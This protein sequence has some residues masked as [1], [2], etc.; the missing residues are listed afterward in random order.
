LRTQW[1]PWAASALIAAVTVWFVLP[2]N[3]LQ[4]QSPLEDPSSAPGRGDTL[5][6]V[7]DHVLYSTDLALVRASGSAAETWADDQLLACAAVEAGLE[8]PAVSRFVAQRAVQLY[9]RDLMVDSL[10][11]SVSPPSEQEILVFMEQDPELYLIERHYYQMIMAD[12]AM[13]DSIHTR[14]GWGQNFQVTAMN[15]SIGQKAGIGGDLGF[16]TGGEMLNHGLPEHVGRLDGLSPVVRSSLGWH[17]FRVTETRAVEDSLRAV[18]SAG[19]V[20]YGR[21]IDAAM[22]SLLQAAEERFTMEVKI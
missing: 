17:I 9:L 13:A 1:I 7:G 20:L 22:D 14:L 5:A 19:E 2:G 8:N 12:S 11:R 6:R 15:V 10:M 3:G 4:G 18:R 16:V 21:R